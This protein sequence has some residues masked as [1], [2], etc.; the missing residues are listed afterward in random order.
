VE[1]ERLWREL[2]GAGRTEGSDG[3]V[4]AL[5]VL[6]VRA[7]VR[8]LLFEAAGAT[9]CRRVTAEALEG[10]LGAATLVGRARLVGA[11]GRV[12]VGACC[13]EAAALLDDGAGA[14]ER[15]WVMLES[16]MNSPWPG[17]HE[18]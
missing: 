13:V 3:A 10:V 9:D 8:R 4:V 15:I 7:G 18:K 5:A 14:S 6:G 1:D 12:V 17:A 11:L 16:R 2:D